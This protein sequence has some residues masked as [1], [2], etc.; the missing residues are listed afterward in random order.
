[1]NMNMNMGGMSGMN[2]NMGGMNHGGGGGGGSG[3][4]SG[5][6]PGFP[7]LTPAQMQQLQSMNPQMRALQIQRIMAVQM[8]RNMQQ[9][10]SGIKY[11][12]CRS[13]PGEYIYVRDGCMIP[14][15]YTSSVLFIQ[16]YSS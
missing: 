14:D 3:G 11:V 7:Q 1:M 15:R 13:V 12:A 5:L 2:M 10:V 16:E 6:P 9:G 4:M 8:E